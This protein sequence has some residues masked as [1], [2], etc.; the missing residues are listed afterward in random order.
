MRT[1]FLLLPC[2]Y[3]AQTTGNIGINT[4]SPTATLDIL[5]SGN[6]NATKAFR[7]SNSTPLE[8][9]TI[10]NDGNVGINSSLAASNTAQLNVNSGALT[11]SVL[12]LNNLSDTK[13]RTVSLIN[14]NQF[15]P[16]AIDNNGNV[17]K[18]FDVRTGNANSATFDGSYTAIPT[19]TNLINLFGGSIVRFQ[20]LTPDFSLGNGDVLYAD[21]TWTRNGGFIVGTF[22]NE[23]LTATANP[24]IINGIG[25]NSLVFNFTNGIDL[26]FN[27]NLNGTTGAGSNIGTLNYNIVGSGS[28]SFNIYYSF[29]SR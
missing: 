15:S 17:L 27:A 11:K 4:T 22:G 7:I 3:F 8:I 12:K 24:M 14:Y 13:A 1:I 5:S 25:T 19:S 26:A 9:L 28:V 10:Q 20:I 23:N 21:I 29:R 2:I 18:Q 6:T 16:L